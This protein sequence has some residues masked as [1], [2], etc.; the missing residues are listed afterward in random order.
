LTNSEFGKVAIIWYIFE[1]TE[2]PV[3]GRWISQ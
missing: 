2:R 1:S 3:I